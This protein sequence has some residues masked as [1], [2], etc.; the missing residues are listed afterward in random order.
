MSHQQL[1]NGSKPQTLKDGSMSIYAYL[2]FWYAP[3][4]ERN[5]FILV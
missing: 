1:F 2:V 4:I 5:I 3:M